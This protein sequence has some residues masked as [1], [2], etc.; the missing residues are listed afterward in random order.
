M[1][2][3]H[4]YSL[5]DLITSVIRFSFVA[6]DGKG[7]K[8]QHRWWPH[9]NLSLWA[10]RSCGGQVCHCS[11][12]I[13]QHRGTRVTLKWAV[14][15]HCHVCQRQTRTTSYKTRWN[16]YFCSAGF[17]KSIVVLWLTS[18]LLSLP[19]CCSCRRSAPLPGKQEKA[20]LAKICIIHA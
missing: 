18:S 1:F 7:K 13:Q 5:P 19:R 12:G 15:S 6:F 4:F 9:T 11:M 17:P 2:I 14:L 10:P 16:V 8:N 3:G 20:I